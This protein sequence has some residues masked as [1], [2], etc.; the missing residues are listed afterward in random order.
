MRATNF[1][2]ARLPSLGVSKSCQLNY[3]HFLGRDGSPAESNLGVVI[4]VYAVFHR[5]ACSQSANQVYLK[6]R[7]P[8][9]RYLPIQLNL[10][11]AKALSAR[12]CC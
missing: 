5:S 10:G 9:T 7:Y 8:S 11:A 2:K 1:R 6:R 4:P 12:L 3:S